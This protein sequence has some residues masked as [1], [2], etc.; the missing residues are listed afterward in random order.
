MVAPPHNRAAMLFNSAIYLFAFLPVA[1]AGYFGLCRL[2]WVTAAQAWLVLASLFFY[3]YW[4]LEHLPLI[5]VSLLVN[6]LIGNELSQGRLTR[7]AV[8]R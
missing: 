4:K 7:S 2:R 6:F 3:S 8:P 1:L 5:L